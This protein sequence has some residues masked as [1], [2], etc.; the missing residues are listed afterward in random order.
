MLGNMCLSRRTRKPHMQQ[1]ILR[2][3]L[4]A[5]QIL[6]N[7][8]CRYEAGRAK[9][10]REKLSYSRVVYVTRL[11]DVPIKPLKAELKNTFRVVFGG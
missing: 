3:S 9:P 1:K 10:A 8:M 5:G 6:T 4:L 11:N 2:G 7:Q